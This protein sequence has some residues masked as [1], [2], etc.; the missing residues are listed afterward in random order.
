MIALLLLLALPGAATAQL[1]S[2]GKLSSAHAELEGMTNCTSCHELRSRGIA[3]DR[4]LA[5]HEPLAARVSAG[6]GLHAGADYRECATCHREHLGREYALVRWDPDEFR[7]ATVGFELEGA[8]ADL[9]C[10]DCHN[11]TRIR[12]LQVRTAKVQQGT[13]DETYLG[14]GTSCVDC[15]QIDDPHEGAFADRSCADCHDQRDWKA[16]AASFDHDATRY[17][18]TGRHRSV[19]CN[20]CHRHDTF[21]GLRFTACTDCHSDPHEGGMRAACTSCHSTSG[22]SG[23]TREAVESGFDV[24]SVA[25]TL[26]TMRIDSKRSFSS[27]LNWS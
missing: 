5:C 22:W 10:R 16:A 1:I 11:P 8:H 3:P 24:I 6:A 4:C 23:V 17:P 12:D 18:L 13:L 19:G 21:T 26:C 2:P 25:S 9:G 20:E 27:S 15:H 7:H 14:L